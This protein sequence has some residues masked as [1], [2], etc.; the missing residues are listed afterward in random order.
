MRFI[1]PVHDESFKLLSMNVILLMTIAHHLVVFTILFNTNQL[2]VD[3]E[4]WLVMI[5]Y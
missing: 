1:H 2:K 4:K 5:H 3:I